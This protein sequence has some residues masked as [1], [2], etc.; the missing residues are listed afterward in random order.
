MTDRTEK[1]ISFEVP[2]NY[3]Y[4]EYNLDKGYYECPNCGEY[5]A[6]THHNKK[7]GHCLNCEKNL[8]FVKRSATFIRID[9]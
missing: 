6:T 5:K 7:I 3:E 8:Q 9:D 2:K 4:S 1:T